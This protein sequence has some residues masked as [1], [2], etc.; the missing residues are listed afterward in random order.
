MKYLDIIHYVAGAM[1]LT[2]TNPYICM[3]AITF[4]RLGVLNKPQSHS[5]LFFP[6]S[7]MNEQAWNFLKKIST[8][9]SM[10]WV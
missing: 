9:F 8:I 3:P 1:K 4:I 10:H 5:N 7:E 6:I 2:D